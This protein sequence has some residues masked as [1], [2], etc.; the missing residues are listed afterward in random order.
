MPPVDRLGGNGVEDVADQKADEQLVEECVAVAASGE[1]KY[2]DG[3]GVEDEA[4]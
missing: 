2:P 1:A 3:E 4:K